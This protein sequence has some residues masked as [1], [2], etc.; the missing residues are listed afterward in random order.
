[1]S[2]RVKGWIGRAYQNGNRLRRVTV[3]FTSKAIFSII[4]HLHAALRHLNKHCESKAAK[5]DI[6]SG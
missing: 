3:P 6:W 4:W 5:C 1:M 2:G